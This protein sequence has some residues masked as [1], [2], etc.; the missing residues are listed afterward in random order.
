ML[1]QIGLIIIAVAWLIQLLFLIKGKK[2]LRLEFV[3]AYLIGIGLLIAGAMKEKNFNDMFYLQILTF[4]A[5]F[6]VLAR[7][8]KIP[9]RKYLEIKVN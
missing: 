7:K 1:D 9:K 6:L 8:L 3:I 4:I 5:A 2:D